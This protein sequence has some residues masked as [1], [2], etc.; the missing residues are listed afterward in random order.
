[1]I[2]HI[3][4]FILTVLINSGKFKMYEIE[5]NRRKQFRIA[6]EMAGMNATEFAANIGVSKQLVT[7][8]IQNP[9][10]SRPVN[11][12]INEFIAQYMN[13]LKECFN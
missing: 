3:S 13:E 9:Q 2:F 6:L 7:Q 1:L 5:M 11:D 12:K 10:V 8:V 4:I